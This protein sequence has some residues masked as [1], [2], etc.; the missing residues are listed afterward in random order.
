MKVA[1]INRS[2]ALALKETNKQKKNKESIEFF[3]ISLY[4]KE[5][6]LSTKGNARDSFFLIK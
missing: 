5:A 6:V 2:E 1:L 3:I 4:I